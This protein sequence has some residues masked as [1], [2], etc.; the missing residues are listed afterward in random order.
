VFCGSDWN[1]EREPLRAI[2]FDGKRWYAPGIRITWAFPDGDCG[3]LQRA[4][5]RFG[6]SE[7]VA[8]NGVLLT[9]PASPVTLRTPVEFTYGPNPPL[10][11]R[12]FTVPVYFIDADIPA[13]V[14]ATP[15][16]YAER[17]FGDHGKWLRLE[18]KRV[19]RYELDDE[20]VALV[21]IFTPPTQG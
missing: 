19:L 9:S 10:W 17:R 7:P 11:K 21:S 13:F 15:V 2:D 6:A 12:T 5:A 3:V 18:G 4:L 1:T 14:G 16:F 8:L 20:P